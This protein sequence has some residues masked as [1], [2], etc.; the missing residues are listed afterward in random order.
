L[1]PGQGRS[2]GTPNI[3]AATDQYY[4]TMKF[5]LAPGG[6]SWDFESA[7]R[8]PS[9]PAGTQPTY[10]DTGHGLCHGPGRPA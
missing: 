3:E 6:Y 9:A 4:G 8:N 10:S 5:T 2:P 1:Q 7:L